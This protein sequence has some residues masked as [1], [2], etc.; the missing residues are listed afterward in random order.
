MARP[1]V[2]S[3]GELHV[4]LNPYGMV[5]D[6]YF[7]YVGL[8]NHTND[9]TL[10]HE[11]GVFVDGALHWIDNDEWR[12][13]LWYAPVGSMIG[14]NRA[15]NDKIGITLEFD[16]FVDSEV[17]AFVRNIRIIN[18]QQRERDLKLFMHQGFIISNA[19]N[20]RDTAQYLPESD[21]I[22]HYKGRRAFVIGGEKAKFNGPFDSYSIGLFGIEGH[23]GVWRDAEDGHLSQNSVEH[24]QVDSI[25]EYDIHLT[26]GDNERVFY[27][28]ACGRSTREA[29]KIHERIRRDGPVHRLLK[30]DQHWQEWS[31]PARDYAMNNLPEKYRK[32][33]VQSVMILKSHLDRHGAVIASTDSAIV[34]YGRDAYGYCWPRDAA[35]VLWPLLRLGYIDE[36]MQFMGFARRALR[37]E[38]YF[39]H[40][41]QSDGSLG[42]SWHS[43]VHD[44]EVGLPIQTDETA[45]IL[46]LFHQLVSMH[47]NPEQLTDYYQTLIRPMANFLSGY[48]D[49]QTKLPHAS[50]DLWEENYLTTTY[51]TAVTYAAL[52]AAAELADK[53]SANDDAVRWRAAAEDMREAAHETLWDEENQYFLK[54]FRH[55]PDGRIEK[56]NDFDASSFYGVYMFGLLDGD[57]PRLARAYETLTNKYGFGIDNPRMPRYDG[58][59]YFRVNPNTPGNPWHITAL[60]MAQYNIDGGSRDVS[61]SVVDFANDCMDRNLILSEQIDPATNNMISVAPLVWS[62]A[63]FINTLMD[64]RE[65]DDNEVSA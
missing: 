30:T 9:W 53:E 29:L 34:K 1:I 25:I 14:H 62:H 11:I 36:T 22:L 21:A 4:G 12:I 26:E 61:R 56:R 41:F 32:N 52:I 31:Q 40:K 51:T 23:E 6:F 63:E 55:F 43:Y 44:G 5:H 50:Y 65:V 57:D 27:W 19:A 18:L 49:P 28:I 54:G 16:S 45:I 47:P 33:F 35:Y 60:W 46:F 24:G 37:E 58:D 3:N 17:S 10:R 38:G 39:M 42:S 7:P 2:L 48:I 64:F 20:N 15:T 8:E 13:E 59:N